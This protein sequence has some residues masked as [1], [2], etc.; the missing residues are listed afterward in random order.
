MPI[1]NKGQRC[2]ILYLEN[3]LATDAFTKKRLE[4]LNIIATEAAIS[5]ENARLF[6]LATTDELTKLYVYRYFQHRL[7]LEIDRSRRY[8]RP[9]TLMLMDIDDFKQFHDTYGRA[10][11]DEAL[12]QIARVLRNTIRNVDIAARY[13][14]ETLIL[15]LPE[16]GLQ[17]AMTVC[18]KIRTLMQQMPIPDEKDALFITVSIGVAAFPQHA[19]DTNG[20]I[21]SV[22]K[23]LKDAQKAGKNRISVGKR[24][25]ESPEDT[26]FLTDIPVQNNF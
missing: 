3:N 17:Q 16:T 19:M 12:Q 24:H 13:R 21:H 6:E 11:A 15:L 23:A 20:L 2:G 14:A 9:I 22:E 26:S 8:Q 4:V 25:T 18:E 7:N 1:M 10:K 5:L